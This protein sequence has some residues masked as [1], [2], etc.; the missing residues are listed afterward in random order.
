MF[1]ANVDICSFTRVKQRWKMVAWAWNWAEWRVVLKSWRA[2][3][4]TLYF[5][6]FMQTQTFMQT[7]MIIHTCDKQLICLLRWNIVRVWSKRSNQQNVIIG[8]GSTPAAIRW[9]ATTLIKFC[10]RQKTFMQTL[11][12]PHT[13]YLIL[14][15]ICCLIDL[16]IVWVWSKKIHKQSALVQVMDWHWSGGKPLHVSNFEQG[17]N[18]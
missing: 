16:N 15:V 8:S 6:G 14:I 17:E 10:P 18:W 13:S 11:T 3:L 12:V 5:E 7:V 9:Q 4:I 2:G 1:A